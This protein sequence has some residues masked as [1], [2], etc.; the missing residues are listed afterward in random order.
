MIPS[1]YRLDHVVARLI[2]RLEGQRPTYVDRQDQAGEAFVRA[3]ESQ[4]SAVIGEFDE[5]GLA[6]DPE[7]QKKFLRE[8]VMETFL[9][10]YATLARRAN[11]DKA[12]G[13]GLGRLADPIGRLGLV[14]GTLLF[15]WLVLLKLIFLPIVWPLLLVTVSVPF[16]PDIVAMVYRRRHVAQLEEIVADMT[17]IQEQQDAYLTPGVLQGAVDAPHSRPE[18]QTERD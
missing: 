16:W 3:T 9:P 6:D 5:I 18:R 10:R 1:D 8:Q 11:A 4:L 13:Y 14:V 12:S 2:E 7:A 17:R 15:S